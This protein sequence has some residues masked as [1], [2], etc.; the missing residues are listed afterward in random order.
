MARRPNNGLHW[1]V[2]DRGL[3]CCNCFTSSTLKSFYQSFSPQRQVSPGV[4][5]K[6]RTMLWDFYKNKEITQIPHRRDYDIWTSRLSEEEM[7][8]IKAEI[9]RRIEGDEIAT[10]GWIPGSDWNDTPFHPIYER[11]CRFDQEA[12]GKC[13][14]L[15]VWE[16]MMEHEDYWGFGR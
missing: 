11:A 16:T 3:Y 9:L 7:R 2:G 1:T 14:G 12:S 10:A 15:I 4:G 8:V 6:G 13:F 5:H